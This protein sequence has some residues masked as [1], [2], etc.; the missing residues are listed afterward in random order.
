V[1][2]TSDILIYKNIVQTLCGQ[3]NYKKPQMNADERR[4]IIWALAFRGFF[5]WLI[6]SNVITG[7]L[8]SAAIR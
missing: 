1:N 7:I 3:F 4:F 8:R 5:A 2:E 6:D